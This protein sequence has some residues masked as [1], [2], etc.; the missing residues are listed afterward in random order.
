MLS[1]QISADSKISI[2]GLYPEVEELSKAKRRREFFS[3]VCQKYIRPTLSIGI[4]GYVLL[5]FISIIIASYVG[6]MGYNLFEHTVS[7]LG[8]S[9]I[10]PLPHL[11]D[12]A[13]MLA[14]IIAF[15][16]Y[17]Y[18]RKK[19]IGETGDNV[20]LQSTMLIGFIGGIGYFFVGVFSLERSGPLYIAH[21]IF[22]ICAFMGFVASIILFSVYIIRY[23]NKFPKSFGIF[24]AVFPLLF[25]ILY[26]AFGIPILEW[27]LLTSIL[28]F[29]V[30]LSL[31]SLL[32]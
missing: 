9:L 23:Q 21:E 10:T 8:L 11:F 28:I 17:F 5:I 31:W 26:G 20:L 22:A 3:V 1:K 27:L 13:C 19:M 12:I 6:S 2:T 30:P 7:E 15:P 18:L 29:S 16:Y 4:I 32:K 25:L 14:G 24:G